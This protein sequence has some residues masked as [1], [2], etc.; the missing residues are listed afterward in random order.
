MQNKRPISCENELA[1]LA[2]SYQITGA[3]RKNAIKTDKNKMNV[4]QQMF[5]D[6]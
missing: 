3:L 2:N 5:A 4:C 6:L 1:Q